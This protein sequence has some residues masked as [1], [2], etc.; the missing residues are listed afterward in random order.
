MD[1]QAVVDDSRNSR[2][3]PD[4]IAAAGASVIVCKGDILPLSGY[5]DHVSDPENSYCAGSLQVGTV[6]SL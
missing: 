6:G 1:L 5:S 3:K 2:F 4:Q